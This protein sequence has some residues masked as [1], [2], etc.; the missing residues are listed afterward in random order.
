MYKN[1]LYKIIA[2]MIFLIILLYLG[3]KVEFSFNR[4]FKGIPSMM[5]LFVRILRPNLSYGN[6]V[7]EKLIETIQMAIISSI[8]GVLLALPFSLL[9]ADNIKPNKFI[10]NII[11]FFFSVARTIPS[12]IWATLLV[13]IF[14][15]GKFSG[16]IALSIIAFLMSLKLFKEYIEGIN[17]NQLNSTLSVGATSIQVLRY[18]IL[19]N[20]LQLI[21]SVF[22]IVF[23]TNIRG[24]TILGLVGAGGVGQIMWRDLN[25]LRYDNLSILIMILFIT[26][27]CIDLFSLYIRNYLLNKSIK[28]KSLKTYKRVKF[29][30]TIFI[31]LSIVILAY[32]T[33]SLLDISYE[34]FLIGLNQGK[35]MLI[36]MVRIDISYY[37]QLIKG[38]KES[39]FIAIFA[40]MVGSIFAFVLAYFTAYNISPQRSISFLLKIII[41]I[42]RT[43]PPIIT[44]IIFFRGVGPGPLAGA[45]ALSIYTTGVLTKMYSEV[46]ENIEENIKNSILSTGA[47]NIQTYVHGLFPHTFS[48]FIS[49]ALYRLESNIRNAT[50]LGIIGAGGIGTILSMNV[51]WR[52][53][54]KVGFL[55]LGS[56][57]MVLVIDR[58]SNSLR[59]IIQN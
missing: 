20:I 23:E 8:T 29:I 16:I 21:V 19:P 9:I 2:T 28:Y 50:I 36:R 10:A 27:L 38:I 25:H 15:I 34:R 4:L 41:N 43:F 58:I 53:W 42:L 44:A 3:I 35:E 30:K 57:L 33:W 47:S 45:M 24:A 7:F 55:L 12:L 11:I 26:I 37:P 46:L 13:S 40:T 6:E 18:C 49:L 51:T 52:N 1:K 39:L 5:N 56:S 54:E 48:T 59:K 22:F 17:E 14:S 32:I 31:P